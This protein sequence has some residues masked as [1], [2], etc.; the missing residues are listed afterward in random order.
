MM[1]MNGKPCAKRYDEVTRDVQRLIIRLLQE[2]VVKH[3]E[4]LSL[5]MLGNGFMAI[6]EM[7]AVRKERR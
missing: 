4:M 3:Y 2:G 5:N 1:E 7:G 6:T